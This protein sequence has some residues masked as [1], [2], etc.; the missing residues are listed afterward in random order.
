MNRLS[1]IEREREM[2]IA[3]NENNAK[4]KNPRQIDGNIIENVE[5]FTYLGTNVSIDGGVTKDVILRIQKTRGVL[6]E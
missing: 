1:V 5:N 3:R 2:E 6:L 4:N